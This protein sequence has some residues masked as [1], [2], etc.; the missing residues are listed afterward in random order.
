MPI[1]ELLKLI[2]LLLKVILGALLFGMILKTVSAQEKQRKKALAVFRNTPQPHGKGRIFL[3]RYASSN[4]FEAPSKVIAG[5]SF[6]LLSVAPSAVAFRGESG[7]GAPLELTFLP[8]EATASWVGRRW[9]NGFFSWFVIVRGGEKHYF[10]SAS[11][12]GVLRSK[13]RT[14]RVYD[15]VATSLA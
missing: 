13:S 3:V 12:F 10:T 15:E 5:N 1:D 7:G 11:G 14:R 9:S 4:N 2:S 8:Q 6:G